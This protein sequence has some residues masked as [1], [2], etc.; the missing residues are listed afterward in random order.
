MSYAGFVLVGGRS[1]R[2]GRDKALLRYKSKTLL[3]HAAQQVLGAAGNVTLI[4]DPALYGQFGFQVYPDRV[5]DCG[6][7]GGLYT[8]LSRTQADWNLVVACDL[9]GICQSQLQVI[10]EAASDVGECVIPQLEDELTE[11]LCAAYH[12]RCLPKI[13]QA[14]VNKSLRMRDLISKL[15]TITLTSWKPGLFHNVNSPA[16]WKNIG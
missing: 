6:P 8:V 12:R 1:S 2:M 3:E 15:S 5:P 16:D 10:L 9:P 14:L 13:E 7:L 11:P 4:G